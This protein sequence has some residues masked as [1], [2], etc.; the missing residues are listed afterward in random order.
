[1][2]RAK[3]GRRRSPVNGCTATGVR[4]PL[5]LQFLL[6]TQPVYRWIKSAE[7]ARNQKRE[8]MG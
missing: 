6:G 4:I 3:T 5:A 1:M 2:V 7:V 8:V